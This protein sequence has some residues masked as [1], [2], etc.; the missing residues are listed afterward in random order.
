MSSPHKGERGPANRFGRL[1]GAGTRTNARSSRAHGAPDGLTRRA[2]TTAHRSR[3]FCEGLI[4]GGRDAG[5]W[6]RS[7]PSTARLAVTALSRPDL[8]THS[9]KVRFASVRSGCIRAIKS[10]WRL[11]VLWVSGKAVRREKNRGAVKPPMPVSRPANRPL[12][13]A[14]GLGRWQP[15]ALARRSCHLSP[16]CR[17]PLLRTV[18]L[19][20][21][22]PRMLPA[23]GLHSSTVVAGIWLAFFYG[24][25]RHLACIL[26]RLLPRPADGRWEHGPT[27]AAP[28]PTEHP[29]A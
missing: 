16:V 5:G 20:C 23:S 27:P 13:A 14:A 28:E 17:R 18:N 22:L 25:C 8:N 12:P 3:R 19:A 4:S 24:C 26:L 15:T 2:R 11:S 6:P 1:P 7:W 10:C 21:I 29:T 9:R